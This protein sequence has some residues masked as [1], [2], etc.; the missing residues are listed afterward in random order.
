MA[1][2]ESA[3]AHVESQMGSR[4]HGRHR[5]LVGF[6]VTV[7]TAIV[8]LAVLV[9]VW[10]GVSLT[11]DA[12]ALAHV[13][14]QPLGGSIQRVEAFGPGGRRIPLTVAGGRLAP[15]QRPKPRQRA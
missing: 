11:S 7:L 5:V 4:W 8:V 9:L 6:A 15:Q 10:S 14:V 3:I 2:T 1:T 12:T 13:S